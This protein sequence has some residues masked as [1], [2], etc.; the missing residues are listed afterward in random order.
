M[1]ALRR[2][3]GARRG[4]EPRRLHQSQLARQA[5]GGRDLSRARGQG[6]PMLDR[7]ARPD[8]RHGLWRTDHRGHRGRACDGAGVLGQ[9]E[10]VPGRPQRDQ[11]RRR[12]R[13]HHRAVPHRQRRVQPRT[14]LLPGPGA[15][16]RR[17]P[18]ADRFLHRRPGDHDPAQPAARRPAAGRDRGRRN[19]RG[20]DAATATA[21]TSRATAA[22]S[23]VAA[24]SRAATAPGIAAASSRAILGG[25]GDRGRPAARQILAAD[26]H[27]RRLRRGGVDRAAVVAVLARSDAGQRRLQRNAEQCGS[28]RQRPRLPLNR[29]RRQAVR[30]AMGPNS[31]RRGRKTR[32][33]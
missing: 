16:A 33:R 29:C 1:L 30:P 24:A 4:D 25:R 15:L 20:G 32:R 22:A 26:D 5:G 14:P 28:R 7:A 18:A 12:R 2:C 9:R 27:R 13:R 11:H 17:L 8:R 19:P 3:V 31:T 23:R 6:H 21:A 10:Q